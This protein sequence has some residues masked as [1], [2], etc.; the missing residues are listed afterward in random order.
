MRFRPIKTILVIIIWAPMFGIT[1]LFEKISDFL[2]KQYN[3]LDT[4]I[5]E[6]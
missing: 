6:F 2:V 5:S 3:K 1:W 4:F